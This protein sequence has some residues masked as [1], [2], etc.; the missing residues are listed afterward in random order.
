MLNTLVA[1]NF[2][3][4]IQS[5]GL[6]AQSAKKSMAFRNQNLPKPQLLFEHPPNNHETSRFRPLITSKPN[7]IV[8]FEQ[9]FNLQ[10]NANGSEQ[11]V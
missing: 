8:P 7:A 6:R 10:A 9:S 4:N 2:G 3:L 1:L 11:C 5:I